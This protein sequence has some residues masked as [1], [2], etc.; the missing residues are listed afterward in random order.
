MAELPFLKFYPSDWL[1]EERLKLCSLAARGLWIEMLC[2][3]HKAEPRGELRVEGVP[4]Q[5]EELAAVVGK[6]VEEIATALAELE[7]WKV[8]SRRKSRVIYSRR[9]DRDENRARKNRENGKKGGNP[10]LR[11]QTQTRKSVNPNSKAQTL[12]VL[13]AQSLEEK[14]NPPPPSSR[15]SVP[16]R[17]PPPAEPLP[18]PLDIPE[19]LDRRRKPEAAQLDLTPDPPTKP[20]KARGSRLP[21]DWQPGPDART[22][23]HS[24]GLTDAEIDSVAERFRDHWHG[25]SGAA[26]RKASWLATWRNWIRSDI[27]RGRVGAGAGR[28][29][30]AAGSRTGGDGAEDR[31]FA[32]SLARAAERQAAGGAAKRGPG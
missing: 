28:G 9:M 16:P 30:P 22:F 19:F 27:D 24:Q 20:D 6:P 5:T 23:A 10:S 3:M 15:E 14:T 4:L 26:A 31:S 32:A 29:K 25:K 8:F 1:G 12:R 7:R 11:K 21:D 13:E 2:L 18:D 17:K